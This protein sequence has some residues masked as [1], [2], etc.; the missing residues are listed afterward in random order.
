ME[1]VRKAKERLSKYPIL[2][3]KCSVSAST[4]AA[5]VTKDINIKQH[6]CDKEFQE[7][8]KCLVEQAKNMKT[9]L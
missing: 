3:A 8:R 9:R 1:S 6:G 5:C 4:Y 2:L 7:F